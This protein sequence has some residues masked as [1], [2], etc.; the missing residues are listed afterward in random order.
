M[1]T[2]VSSAKDFEIHSKKFR[3]AN[4]VTFLFSKCHISITLGK[5]IV[6]LRYVGSTLLTFFVAERYS[7]YNNSSALA[8]QH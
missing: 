7:F 1:W 3:L 4:T 8:W 2:V 6:S 5:H